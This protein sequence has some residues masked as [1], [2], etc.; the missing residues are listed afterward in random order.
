MFISY[1]RLSSLRLNYIFTFGSYLSSYFPSM[2]KY[3]LKFEI[4]CQ[5]FHYLA[6]NRFTQFFVMQSRFI[7]AFALCVKYE[8]VLFYIPAGV[9]SLVFISLLLFG[10]CYS[11][12]V[13]L[14]SLGRPRCVAFFCP[15]RTRAENYQRW[16]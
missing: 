16:Y 9:I 6:N 8:L 11:G 5:D 12:C 1:I 2:C 4:A 14:A 3:L 10:I 7:F 15:G 13:R